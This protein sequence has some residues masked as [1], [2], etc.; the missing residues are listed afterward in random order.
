MLTCTARFFAGCYVELSRTFSLPSHSK[1]R[2]VLSHLRHVAEV[3]EDT[4]GMAL[5][6]GGLAE[7]LVHQCKSLRGRQPVSKTCL[8]P[9]ESHQP[10]G[11]PKRCR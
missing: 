1:C 8:S 6:Y 4:V 5:Y 2:E 9:K 10:Q 7:L 11:S 3:A